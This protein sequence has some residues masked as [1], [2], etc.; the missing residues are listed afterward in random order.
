MKPQKTNFEA[1][2]S[3]TVSFIIT[4][5]NREGYL[6]KA[7]ERCRELITA[8][9]EL[10]IVDG[11]S[12]DHT[13]E[14]VNQ[15]GDMVDV[16]IS[17]S[18]KSGAHA[19][20]KGILIARGK[21][22]KQ[23]PDDDIIYPEPMAQAIKVLEQHPE[24]D[25]LY[26]GGTRQIGER[27]SDVYIAPGINYG[28]SVEDVFRYGATGVGFIYRRS[29]LSRI[30][31]IHPTDVVADN[32]IILRAIARGAN[33]KFCRIKLFHHKIYD[34]SVSTSQRRKWEIDRDRLL[35]R[36]CSLSFC[37]RYHV[38]RL[39]GKYSNG[40]I[41]WLLKHRRLTIVAKTLRDSIKKPRYQKEPPW[42]EPVWD[43]GFS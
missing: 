3:K 8:E 27:L 17:E 20:N 28:K 4:T 18:D 35:R 13:A 32:E 36:Y 21:Y 15:Y 10:I 24:V 37:C 43:S 31:L 6:K 22:I 29:S 9:D 14:V 33:V 30:G 39:I 16:F 12:T 42:K 40:L 41:R 1:Y 19:L 2:A 5:K 34:H 38:S 23:L 11:L 7:L 25:I 26:C